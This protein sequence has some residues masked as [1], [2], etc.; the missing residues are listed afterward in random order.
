[1]STSINKILNQNNDRL[2]AKQAAELI[3]VTSSTLAVWRCTGKEKI[4]YYKIGK[5]V[6]Y[7]TEHILAWIETKKVGP[8]TE[9]ETG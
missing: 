2:D 5:K 3:G 7:K 4:P 8:A 9:E 1:M 6:F